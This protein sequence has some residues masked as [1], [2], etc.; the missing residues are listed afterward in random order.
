[1]HHLF[2]MKWNGLFKIAVIPLP[3]ILSTGFVFIK[4]NSTTLGE[5][6]EDQLRYWGLNAM[7]GKPKILRIFSKLFSFF[8]YFDLKNF[9]ISGDSTF[10]AG[11]MIDS[12]VK[13]PQMTNFWKNLTFSDFKWKTTIL[14]WLE[15]LSL[16]NG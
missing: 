10:L 11:L 2:G 16:A 6:E 12:F 4:S 1:M 3:L 7:L 14:I 15:I 13:I 8:L 5:N 9:L